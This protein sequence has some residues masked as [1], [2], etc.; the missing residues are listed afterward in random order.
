ML[1]AA[2]Q[3]IGK[4]AYADWSDLL[5]YCRYAAAPLGRMACRLAGG[6]ATALAKCE[7]LAMGAMLLY[8]A[9][10]AAAH[11]KWLGRVY[12]PERWLRDA[13]AAKEDLS[14]ARSSEALSRVFARQIDEAAQLI[15]ASRG[16]DRGF[17]RRRVRIG[18]ALAQEEASR[19]ARHLGECDLL[20]G[21]DPMPR[22]G[23]G[24]TILGLWR[25]L[26]P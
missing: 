20:E 11:Y 24:L 18:A 25:G 10:Q 22:P 19:W 21:A 14:A 23:L 4:A 17:A 5:A 8:L 6:R 2:G 9:E 12:L 26:P 13:G 16:L 3:D 15:A 1:Q 7:T